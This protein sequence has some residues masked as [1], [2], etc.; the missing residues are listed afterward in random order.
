M[1]PLILGFLDDHTNEIAV[2]QLGHPACISTILRS[3]VHQASL[4]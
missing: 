2:G 4:L 3:I 1:E